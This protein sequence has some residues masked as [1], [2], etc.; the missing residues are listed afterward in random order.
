[1]HAVFPYPDKP[2]VQVGN[3]HAV[4]LVD[5]KEK[6]IVWQD[7]ISGQTANDWN[8]VSKATAYVED[9]QLF[10]ADADS[11]YIVMNSASR[12]ARF[13]VPMAC[14]WHSIAWTRVW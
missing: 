9:H 8:A 13:G 1:M 5:F 2:I 7:S 10:V 3:R 14:A 12:K 6:R 11:P 4:I